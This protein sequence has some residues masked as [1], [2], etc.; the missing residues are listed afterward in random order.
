MIPSVKLCAD[1]LLTKYAE[2][3]LIEYQKTDVLK[4]T[5]KQL[6][7]ADIIVLGRLNTLAEAN[8][9]EKIKNATKEILYILDDDLLNLPES[10]SSYHLYL[11]KDIKV[12]ITKMLNLAD[13]II[14]PSPVLLEKY[15]KSKRNILVEEPAIS[16]KPPVLRKNKDTI[17]IGFAGSI[18]RTNDLNSI[19]SN[20]LYSIHKRYGDRIQFEFFGAIPPF[21]K[22]L[23]SKTY[24]YLDSY[25]NYIDKL[26]DLSWDIGLA[27]MPASSFH[28]CKH[29]IKYIEYSSLGIAGIYSDEMPYIRLKE[30]NAPAIFV[31][32]TEEDWVNELSSLIENK[33]KLNKYKESC[34][35]YSLQNFSC[36]NIAHTLLPQFTSYFKYKAQ[37][38]LK[39][40][41]I[42]NF[43]I[44][45]TFCCLK[46]VF[47]ANG[48]KVLP[49]LLVKAK[50]RIFN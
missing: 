26:K 9:C 47:K 50:K 21:A 38:N 23:H 34:Y 1:F 14:S 35:E 43:K 37:S 22:N 31:K 32:N 46:I 13:G 5:T 12:A 33:E 42:L 48:I 44:A 15:G 11:Q 20:A 24:Q 40:I 3:N 2:T 17:T 29:Y 25:E 6:Q 36:N 39:K 45:W 4:I 28:S 8:L 30:N 49:K 16:F 10:S 18:D 27:P 19:L 7:W 41:S